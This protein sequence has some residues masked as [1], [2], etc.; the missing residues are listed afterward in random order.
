M[1]TVAHNL[2]N[3]SVESGYAHETQDCAVRAMAN[4]FGVPYAYA[5]Q[6]FEA[7]GRKS[8][9]PTSV[10]VIKNIVTQEHG[11]KKGIH[12]DR[13]GR[14][15]GQR[16]VTISTF[17]RFHPTGTYYCIVSDHAFAVVNGVVQDTFKNKGGRRI[18]LAYEIV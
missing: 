2:H 8:S 12:M 7:A 6:V 3:P 9:R 15:A 14:G 4:A 1:K 10:K 11:G 5:H 17:C 16:Q 13:I 18:R